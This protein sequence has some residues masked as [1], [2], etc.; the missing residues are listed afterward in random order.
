MHKWVMLA[1]FVIASG[2]AVIF[3]ITAIEN[4]GGEEEAVGENELRFVMSNF[5]FDQE[6]Y[7]VKAGSTMTLSMK[8][9]QGIHGVAIES[10][11]VDMKEG[12]TVEVTFGEAGTTYD[13]LCSVMCGIGH[14]EMVSKIVVE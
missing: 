10:L 1:L 14:A 9:A 3:S 6:T 13:L 4:E 7:T 5:K 12:D 11:G 2:M 8:N